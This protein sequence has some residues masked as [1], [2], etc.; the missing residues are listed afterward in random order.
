MYVC[1]CVHVNVYVCACVRVRCMCICVCSVHAVCVCMCVCG[2]HAEDTDVQLLRVKEKPYKELKDSD[3]RPDEEVAKE[4]RVIMAGLLTLLKVILVYLQAWDYHLS[5]NQSIIVDL[6]QGQVRIEPA[7]LQLI[8]MDD[9]SDWF[10]LL[11][12]KSVVRCKVCN[13]QSVRFDP[14]TFLSLPLP[15]ESTVNLEAVGGCGHMS[16]VDH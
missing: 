15:M 16:S 1:A 14:F 13:Y 3:G 5:R 2:V 12:L 10:F 11:Q 4:V 8:N 7:P 6:F 9:F